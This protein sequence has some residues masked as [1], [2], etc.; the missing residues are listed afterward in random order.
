[1][2]P[3]AKLVFCRSN[4]VLEELK[5]K[6]IAIR[7]L[8]VAVVVTGFAAMG[9][10][11]AQAGLF[12]GRCGC[13]SMCCGP[14]LF[15]RCCRPVCCQPTCCETTCCDSGCGGCSDCGGGCG[16]CGGGCG[17][18]GGCGGSSAPMM[19]GGEHGAPT[20]APEAPKDAPEAPV[21]S[22]A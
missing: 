18:C 16:D 21:D 3:L 13:R 22:A 17:G 15:H 11:E 10:S 20:P 12:G 2:E 14:R 6:S 4:W 9:Q 5:M 7:L 1:M 19:E 8:A